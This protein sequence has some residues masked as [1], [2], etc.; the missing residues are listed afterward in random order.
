LFVTA[1]SPPGSSNA[2]AES[3]AESS[4]SLE[5][6]CP[7]DS[8]PASPAPGACPG[9]GACLEAAETIP[10]D[11]YCAWED[12]RLPIFKRFW[13]TWWETLRH[14]SRFT[15][16]LPLNSQTAGPTGY[17]FLSYLT[18]WA[19]ICILLF[20]SG[21]VLMIDP[22]PKR[23]M[24]AIPGEC[25]LFAAGAGSALLY[26]VSIA[27]TLILALLYHLCIRILGG[28]GKFTDSFR[29]TAYGTGLMIPL[30]LCSYLGLAVG[31]VGALLISMY[32]SVHLHRVSRVRG[33]V[34]FFLCLAIPAGIGA[35]CVALSD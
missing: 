17:A 34:A 2:K 5:L 30:W 31:F 11:R 20:L 9:R 23:A 12:R 10:P 24:F 6:R 18:I 21:T 27:V 15:S 14:P 19:P 8:A 25:L 7:Y 28:R 22:P 29:L 16:A 26:P 3:K 35:A 32:G 33:V 1:R 13:K 4:V